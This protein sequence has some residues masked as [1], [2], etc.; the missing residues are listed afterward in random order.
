MTREISITKLERDSQK[1]GEALDCL[2][3]MRRNVLSE[4]G[5]MPYSVAKNQ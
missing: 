2:D 4:S 1:W 5:E 3:F